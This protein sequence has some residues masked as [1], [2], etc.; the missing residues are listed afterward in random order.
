MSPL[1]PK[2]FP[3]V[4]NAWDQVT[5][6][7]NQDGREVVSPSRGVLNQFG[8]DYSNVEDFKRRVKAARRK[9][10]APFPRLDLKYV[11]GG[12]VIRPGKTAVCG[13]NRGIAF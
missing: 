13:S 2:E 5:Y 1:R 7:V 11:D 3:V 4:L 9:V 6:S 12:I 10:R 8:G